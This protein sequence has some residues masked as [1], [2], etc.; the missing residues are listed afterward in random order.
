MVIRKIKKEIENIL[1]LHDAQLLITAVL[2][3]SY[4]DYLLKDSLELP[5]NEADKLIN[6]AN[7]I[8]GGEPLQY[9]VGM[10]EFMSLKFHVTPDVLIPRQDTEILVE[11]ACEYI[12]DKKLNVLDIGTGS[13]CVAISIA[14]YCSKCAVTTVD[15]SKAALKV[16]KRNA[17][18]NGVNVEFIN[19]DILKEYPERKF[20]IIV[21]NPPYIPTKDIYGLDTTVKDYEPF[22]ALDGGDDGLDFYRRII[23]IA[24]LI[25]NK[26]GA[27]MF[28][29]G[30]DQADSVASL[31]QKDFKNIRKIKDLCSIERVVTAEY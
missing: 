8:K 12:K 31:C 5:Q 24:P 6:L 21:S 9:V 19:C 29:V 20:D 23:N 4:T 1:G 16:A 7:R 11:T 30:H 26:N 22:T 18:E 14:R 13:G 27:L 10:T 28:E 25:L 3:I 2:N 15:I 17:E